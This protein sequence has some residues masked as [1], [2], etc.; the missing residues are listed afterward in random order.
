MT[1]PQ[2]PHANNLRIILDYQRGAL[3]CESQLKWVRDHA[4]RHGCRD[5]DIQTMINNLVEP[6][7]LLAI[8]E[9]LKA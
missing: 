2:P 7:K 6:M 4:F 8:T 1:E 9:R 5:S 3:L